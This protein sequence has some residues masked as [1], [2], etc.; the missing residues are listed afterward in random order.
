MS[1]FIYNKTRL[2]KLLDRDETAFPKVIITYASSIESTPYAAIAMPTESY[3]VESIINEET[4]VSICVPYPYLLARHSG[5]SG[6]DW[7]YYDSSLKEDV[8]G[9]WAYRDGEGTTAMGTLFVNGEP[10]GYEI[11]WSNHNVLYEDETIFFEK[12]PDPVPADQTI[13][14]LSPLTILSGFQTGTVV[15]LMRE[16]IEKKEPVGYLYGTP[17]ENGNIALR[18]GDV[19]TCY[20]GAVLPQLPEFDKQYAV[21]RGYTD[22]QAQKG[23][24]YRWRYL[25]VSEEPFCVKASDSP[26]DQGLYLYNLETEHWESNYGTDGAWEYKGEFTF[27]EQRVYDPESSLY[28]HHFLWANHNIV[29]T[30]DNSTYC[31]ATDPIPVTGIVDYVGDIPIYER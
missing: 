22:E 1:D 2:P 11:V 7:Q 6:E 16:K 25:H 28:E 27:E 15:R 13:Q 3:M 24:A 14:T 29:N 12:S 31:A 21:I 23:G 9:E 17:S 30:V 4:I 19:I 8:Y 10:T 26:Y 18:V 5:N 20:K